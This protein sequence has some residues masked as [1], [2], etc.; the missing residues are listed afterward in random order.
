VTDENGEKLDSNPEYRWMSSL[1]RFERY[2][3]ETREPLRQGVFTKSLTDNF[4]AEYVFFKA[5]RK[6]RRLRDAFEPLVLFT[7][8]FWL[9]P[10]GLPLLN[11]QLAQQLVVRV[12]SDSS[13]CDRP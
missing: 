1:K 13:S 6:S 5:D 8:S 11:S 7:N 9:R 3:K 12:V 2:D 4:R 10:R